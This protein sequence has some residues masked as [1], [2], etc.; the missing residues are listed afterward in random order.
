MKRTLFSICCFL[1]FSVQIANA[2]FVRGSGGGGS[3]SESLGSEINTTPTASYPGAGDA[4]AITGW[5]S[6]ATLTSETDPQIGTYNI[7]ITFDA[8][9]ES[10]S[11]ALTGFGLSEGTTYKSSWYAKHG[12]DG[13]G[14]G[15]VLFGGGASTGA[16]NN[17][18]LYPVIVNTETTYAQKNY[19][20]VYSSQQD[21]ISVRENNSDDD[22]T[23]KID[24]LSFKEL[25]SDCFGSE[26]YTNADAASI[27]NEAEAA[28]NWTTSSATIAA[29][30]A[31]S[32]QD[33]SWSLLFTATGS[34]G[35]AAI[36]LATYASL[37]D[38]TDYFIS[39]YAYSGGGDTAFVGLAST[40]SSSTPNG[41]VT[42]VTSSDPG[43]AWKKYGFSFHY[44]TG[45]N[46]TY[47][48]ILE[49]GTNDNATIH[50]DGISIK[51][52]Q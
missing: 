6:N 43:S 50:V 36:D 27:S 32:A 40:A 14:T 21:Y 17:P 5:T 4:D 48:K 11:Y 16:I 47:F 30:S 13:I 8:A 44:T 45:S 15:D 51:E 38:G 46:Y 49:A 12:G 23:I 39:Y 35:Y 20:F 34:G 1:F 2:D 37:V 52:I 7:Q 28:P 31:I 24:N 19:Y 22:G 41:S 9:N 29:S 26:L 42:Q 10:G 18:Y 25:I 33:G 3:C